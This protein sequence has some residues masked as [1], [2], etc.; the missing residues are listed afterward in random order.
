VRPRALLALAVL[1]AT[2]LA[3]PLAGV[4]V[5]ERTLALGTTWRF[6]TGPVDPYDAFRGRYV[7]LSFPLARDVR[8]LPPDAE[9]GD[10]VWGVLG[11]D[12]DGF[13]R[14]ERFERRR[15]D[16][17]DAVRARV[18]YAGPDGQGSLELPFSAYYLPE[19]LAPAADRAYA[20]A[21]R[22]PGGGTAWVTVKVRHGHAALEDLWLDGRS[23]RDVLTDAPE[24]HSRP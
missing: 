22:R 10:K 9:A 17:V 3:V 14:F 23:I 7:A 24:P 2:Q 6:R 18:V 15:P 11:Q 5:Q 21:T 13:A 8:G 4:V 16:D 1:A 20:E 12:E 19:E